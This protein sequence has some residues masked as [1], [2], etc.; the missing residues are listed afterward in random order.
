M[1]VNW[2]G[3]RFITTHLH[4][5]L[6]TKSFLE[7]TLLPTKLIRRDGMPLERRMRLRSEVRNGEFDAQATPSVIFT[8]PLQPPD[9]LRNP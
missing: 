7:K 4:V 8:L 5:S 9:R 1:A 3:A 6:V 2:N